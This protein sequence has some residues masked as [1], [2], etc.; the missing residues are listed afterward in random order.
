ML[1]TAQ[2]FRLETESGGS[3]RKRQPEI[4]DEL[5]SHLEMRTADN[6]AD[7]MTEVRSSAG[8]TVALRESPRVEGKGAIGRL[9]FGSR[10]FRR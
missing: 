4:N 10:R 1:A 8:G 7:G 9:D 3:K 6:I 2:G 5:L